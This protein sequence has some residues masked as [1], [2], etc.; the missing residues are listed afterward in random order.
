MSQ[1]NIL[2]LFSMGR[3]WSLVH[4]YQ[5]NKTQDNFPDILD[6]SL[7]IWWHHY[8]C[9]DCTHG[10]LSENILGIMA[11]WYWRE[12]I[13]WYLMKISIAIWKMKLKIQAISPDT[14]NVLFTY[15]D[16]INNP[17]FHQLGTK[18][19]LALCHPF[20][21]QLGLI[22]FLINSTNGLVCLSCVIYI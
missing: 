14:C 15:R 7:H 8:F 6:V 3:L 20:R 21:N 13:L 17:N 16:I 11:V 22:C 19:G 2:P 1:T 10:L 5:Y 9:L 12:T 4:I 18:L